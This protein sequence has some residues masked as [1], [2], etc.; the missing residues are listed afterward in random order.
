MAAL[1][2]PASPTVGQQYAASNGVTYQWDGA[3]WIITGGVAGPP[4]GP[5]GGSLA[6]TYPNPSLAPGST[7]TNAPSTI[8]SLVSPVGTTLLL[9]AELTF[10]GT[11]GRPHAV[12]GFVDGAWQVLVTA[13]TN[14]QLT[15]ALRRGGTA[16]GTD[17]AVTGEGSIIKY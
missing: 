8:G 15:I 4:T 6:G 1:D 13:A 10:T 16:G 5:A 12:F 14:S 2:F 3:A 11:A 9:L 7:L 17:G